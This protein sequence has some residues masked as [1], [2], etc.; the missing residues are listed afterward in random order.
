MV[1]PV[2]GNGLSNFITKM[3]KV[4]AMGPIVALEATVTIGRT[5]Q[6]YKRGGFDEARERAI[7]ETTGAVV[8]LWGVKGLNYLGD[9]LLSKILGTNGGNF[10]VGEDILRTPFKNFMQQCEKTKFTAKQVAWMKA[11]KVLASIVLADV[12]IGLCMPKINQSLT[13]KLINKKKAS[14]AEQQET[15]KVQNTNPENTKNN[16]NPSFKGGLSAINVFTNA[17][18][19]TN[20]GKLL[21]TDAGLVSGRMYSARNNDERLEIGIRDIGSIYFYM[22][23]QGHIR[24]FLNYLQTGDFNRLN[25]ETAQELNEHLQK[26]LKDYNNEMS[27]EDFRKAILG[28]NVKEI[29]LPEG[30]KFETAE[31]SKISKFFSRFFKNTKEPLQVAKVE[32]IR[33][34]GLPENIMARIE[35]MSKLQPLRQGEAVITKAQIIDAMNECAIND[36]KFLDSV[37]S[38]FTGKKINKKT[39]EVIEGAS[40]NEFRYVSEDSLRKLKAE[41]ESY[42]EQLCKKAKDGKVTQEVLAKAKK[43]NLIYSGLNFAT[44]FVIAAA[45]LSTLIPKFQYW[46]TKKRTGNDGFPGLQNDGQREKIVLHK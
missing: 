13:R 24:E 37:F 3:T 23:A 36:F 16:S 10:D 1:Q 21:S 39:Q 35:E 27:V 28:K 41:M 26:V 33:A 4:D 19:K 40:K 46:V 43:N 22:W 11:G 38:N 31:P 9:K 15:K 44:G 45:F 42:V 25:P 12:F 7:E 30:I 34:L 17:I 2:S 29:K 14:L 32:E 20:T 18:E 6:A 8:W 5:I